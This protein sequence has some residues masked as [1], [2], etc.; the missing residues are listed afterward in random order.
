MLL[1]DLSGRENVS[2]FGLM[3]WLSLALISL[4]L[5]NAWEVYRDKFVLRN[6]P[7]TTILCGVNKGVIFMMA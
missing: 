5:Q 3:G 1:S 7:S 6:I 4:N 2:M